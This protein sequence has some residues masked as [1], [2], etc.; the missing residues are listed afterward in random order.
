MKA[1]LKS[2]NGFVR[3]LLLH[4]EKIGI[5]AILMVAGLL[6]FKS[7]G[8]EKLGPE[9]QPERLKTL[10]TQA[11]QKVLEATWDNIPADQKV[12]SSLHQKRSGEIVMNPVKS[13]AFPTIMEMNPPVIPPVK[14]RMDPQLLTAQKL[15]VKGGSGLWMSADPAVIKQKMIEALKKAEEERIEQQKEQEKMA[16]EAER[17]GGR[18]GGFGGEGRMGGPGGYG[19]GRM[20]EGRMGAMGGYGEMGAMNGQ[21]TKDG[22]F[23]VPPMGGSQ[24]QGFEDIRDESWVTVVAKVPIKQQVQ[25][26]E[27]ALANSRGFNAQ[28]DLPQ[29][30]GYYIERAEVT[31]GGEG[32][33]TPLKAVTEK[34]IIETMS[35]W[36]QQTPEVVKTNYV[37]PILTHPLPPMV[38]R[39]WGDEATHSDMPLPTPEELAR[40][41][42]PEQPAEADKEKTKKPDETSDDPFAR[43]LTPNQGG[44]YGYGGPGRGEMGMYGGRGG[45][46]GMYGRGGEGMGRPMGM[47]GPGMYG[48]R[49]GE[50]GMY[51]GRGGE[52][53]GRPGMYGGRGGEGMMMG[54]MMGGMTT[55]GPT[56]LPPYQWDY[57]TE[58]VLLRYF[59]N[60]V[61]PGHRYKYRV[62]LVL[63]D[64][65]AL[66]PEAILDKEVQDRVH[67]EKAESKK[68]PPMPKGYRL[69]D[70]SE[71]SP[72]AVVPQ[73]GLAFIASAKP[74]NASNP[75]A[76][77]EAKLVVKSLDRDNAAEVAVQDGFIRGTVLNLSRHAQVI[78]SSLYKVDMEK[79][80][81]S[82]VFDMLT[83]LTL[84]DFEG[85]ESLG[86]K[87]D[88]TAPARALMMDS[89]G[90]MT[91]QEELTDKKGI[92]QFE[93]IL[94]ASELAAKQERTMRNEGG[95]GRG[96]VRGPGGR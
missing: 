44:A 38:I 73:P 56:E 31:D 18:G 19:R 3:F 34:A 36:P 46:M 47:G 83:V 96:P 90:R 40:G 78:W 29:Y 37:H 9:K 82:P 59:D 2:A 21:K 65:N 53:M 87:K 88:L 8:R 20:G 79:P 67:K 70:W 6:I 81:E 61:E 43:K 63:A 60:T 74:A 89:A 41:F 48:G 92:R 11:N 93:A 17:Q 68:K 27:D 1:K 80:T 35:R 22:A 66:Q 85:G 7:L 49:G 52:G 86:R 77:P 26:Y 32:K 24:M 28:N 91:I 57:K 23:V 45:E 12:D 94:K 4:G 30:L 14:P 55:T 95:G 58:Y 54:G 10:A 16:A 71:P 39:T 50:M 25:M 62:R 76:E 51:G 72:V 33:W 15:E 75:N 69:T 5:A 84:L 64:V 42:M 13:E